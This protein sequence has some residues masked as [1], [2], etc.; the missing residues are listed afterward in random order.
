M[1][2]LE[3]KHVTKKFKSVIANEDV[4]LSVE[5]GTIHA[6]LGENGAGKST[7]MNI[8]YGMY[9]P[10]SGEIF[11]N[12]V[13]INIKHPKEAIKN[14]I[15]MVHQHFM[16]IPALSAVENVILGLDGN[17]FVLDLNKAAKMFKEY[18]DKYEMNLD[19]FVKVENMTVGQQQRL[20]IMKALFRKA[21]L[22]IL[23]EPTAVLTP[24]EVDNLF[25]MLNL[26]KKEGHTIIFISH[27]L[28]EILKICDYCTVLR[29]GRAVASMPVSNI[30][31]KSELATLMVGKSVQLTVDRPKKTAGDVVLD[32]SDL[33]YHEKGHFMSLKD[34]SFNIRSGE[35]L[36][37]CG[38]D[39]NGQ[40]ELLKC[41]NGV[42]KPSGGK[43]QI[44]DT[45]TTDRKTKEILKLG[46]SHIPEDRQHMGM[47]GDMS[48]AE[49][50]MLMNI[51][52]EP[53]EKK[54]FAN[55]KWVKKH[56]NEICSSFD[57]KMEDV[58]EPIGKLSGGNQQKLVVGRE[59]DRK[60]SLLIAAHP[61]RGLDIGATKY[62]QSC[63]MN[64][65]MK[66]TAVLLV[67]T[68]LDEL[69]ELS[70]KIM[71]MYSGSS[72]GVYNRNEITREKIGAL[73]AGIKE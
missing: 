61:T 36:G 22:L 59:L 1:A 34:I 16:L 24:K 35:V 4:C 27:K 17:K 66:G 53:Y 72:M 54:G 21:D 8:L 30:K 32:V 11:L 28:M 71:V 51:E 62:I 42:V 18:S 70:D 73:M 15:G 19:P 33:C 46:V 68:E 65:R 12:G 43:V 57:V 5:K 50:V 44:K 64:E 38:V 7:L 9:S 45:V 49:N 14:G 31:D 23:D 58:N 60:P 26:L 63:I 6:L 56:T 55:W 25:K 20:E 29:Q 67:S 48:L 37:V 39:G 2:F 13:K 3:M 69:L 41:I 47:V 10:T 52:N 40:S